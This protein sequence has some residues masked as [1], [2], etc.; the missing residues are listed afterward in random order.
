M[1]TFLKGIFTQKTEVNYLYFSFLM[2]FLCLLSALHYR[3]QPLSGFHLFFLLYSVGQAFF[4]VCLFGLVTL[5]LK[6]WTPQWLFYLFICGS[7]VVLLL[8]FTNFIMVRLLDV[9]VAYLFKLL[10]GSGMNQLVTGFQALNLN[11]TTLAIVAGIFL[12]IPLVSIGFYWLTL[13]LTQHRP[14][15]LSIKQISLTIGIIGLSLFLLD[16]IAHPHLTSQIHTKYKKTLPLGRTFLSPPT[17]HVS[18]PNPFPSFR[19]ENETVQKIPPMNLAHKPNI[20]FFVIESFR[21]DFLHAAPNLTQFGHQH[22]QFQNSFANANSS[23]LSWFALFHADLPFYWASMRDEW[24]RGSIPLQMLKKM[25]YKIH[26]YSS[27]ELSYFNIDRLILGDKR[28]LAD[29]FEQYGLDRK[30]EAHDRDAQAFQALKRDLK[31]EGHAYFIFLDSPHS[32]YSF[33]KDYP[34]QFTPISQEIDYLTISPNS[35]ELELIKNRYRNSI[36]YVD[37]LIGQFFDLLKQENLYDDA[38]ISITGDHAEEFFEE[39][40]LFHATHLNQYQTSV[41]I[42]LKMASPEWVSK[43][44][45]ATHIDIFPSILHHLTKQSDFIPNLFDGRSIFSN[46]QLPYRI[47]VQQNGPDTPIEFLIERNQ[48][49]L[50]ANFVDPSKLEIVELEGV[51]E[52]DIFSPSF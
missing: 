6:R 40:A 26:F 20:Y 42:L 32:E 44:E 46:D 47:A 52:P 39:G 18:L 13:R 49:K 4:E 22:I 27:A 30:M 19:N 29:H 41:P 23:H 16:L 8:H 11:G 24:T 45:K 12:A 14:M 21:K 34:L 17:V 15:L 28:E 25:G 50:H 9:S 36:H 43:T 35:P 38:I 48:V 5:L 1:K 51:L 31:P 2:L 3:E 33:P 10:F 37:H 7:F